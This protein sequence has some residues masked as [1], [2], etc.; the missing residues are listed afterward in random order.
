M[1]VYP[2]PQ[3]IQPYIGDPPPPSPTWVPYIPPPLT[4]GP[5]W[6]TLHV[7]GTDCGTIVNNDGPPYTVST[8]TR[9]QNAPFTYTSE[10]PA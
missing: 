8:V 4:G 2:P 7:V 6:G 10:L 5:W 9:P 1:P 3:P